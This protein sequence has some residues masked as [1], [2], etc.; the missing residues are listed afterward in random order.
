MSLL[1]GILGRFQQLQL[2]RRDQV[3][4][5]GVASLTTAA[6]LFRRRQVERLPEGQQRLCLVTGGASGIGL[7]TVLRLEELGW[8]VLAVDVDETKLSE[9]DAAT[10]RRVSIFQCDISSPEACTSLLQY[11]TDLVATRGLNGLDGLANI[12][13]LMQHCPAGAVEDH[14]LR[15][16]L[17]VNCEAPVRLVRLLM[18]LL[19]A[20]KRPTICNVASITADLPLLWSGCYSATKGF[21]SN[22][23][24]SLRREAAVNGLPLRVCTIKPGFITTPMIDQLMHSQLEWCDKNMSNPF[25]PGFHVAAVRNHFCLTKRRYP[26]ILGHIIALFGDI[27]A[28]FSNP[29]ADVAEDVVRSMC[30][31]SPAISYYTAKLK[32]KATIMAVQILPGHLRDWACQ[33]IC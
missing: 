12:A 32:F 5:L 28:M 14:Q 1:G 19:L 13:G 16:I 26:G 29:P 3:A 4:L 10:S 24:D 21:I 17:A 8:H 31:V 18:P 6:C 11:V 25:K 7:A 9:L 27:K 20:T 30:L 33:Y 23:S 22:F 2:S 15:K